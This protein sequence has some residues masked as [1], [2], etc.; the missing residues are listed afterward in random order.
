MSEQAPVY[1]PATPEV[2]WDRPVPGEAI[3]CAGCARLAGQVQTLE[4]QLAAAKRALEA[5]AA[6]VRASKR[7]GVA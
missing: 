3:E 6:A 1:T 7:G 5:Q 4:R 2:A